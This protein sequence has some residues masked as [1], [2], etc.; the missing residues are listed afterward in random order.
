MSTSPIA[1]RIPPRKSLMCESRPEPIS[2][3]RAREAALRLI[4]SHFGVTPHARATIPVHIDDDDV[5]ILDYI[6]EQIEKELS[7]PK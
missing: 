1:V 5:V 3:E 4:H 7:L 6:Q 2:H